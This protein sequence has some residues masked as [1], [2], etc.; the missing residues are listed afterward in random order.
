[1]IRVEDKNC[2]LW[3]ALV[4]AAYLVGSV[5]FGGIFGL[6]GGVYIAGP[7]AVEFA[8][9]EGKGNG[10]GLSAEETEFLKLETVK[11]MR[12][13]NRWLWWPLLKAVAWAITGAFLGFASMVRY[14]FILFLLF[15]IPSYFSRST[16]WAPPGHL[17][18]EGV[19]LLISAVVFWASRRLIYRVRK[20]T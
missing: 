18:I 11:R 19:A 20:R 14:N 6:F 8:S 15:S 13:V 17:V 10:Q 9:T 12:Q 16:E 5:S 4:L 7:L 3:L 1:M 2:F